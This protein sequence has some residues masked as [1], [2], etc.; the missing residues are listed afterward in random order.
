MNRRSFLATLVIPL[1]AQL[2]RKLQTGFVFTEGPVFNQH[3]DLYFSD[4]GEERIYCL[5]NG[6]RRVVRNSSKRC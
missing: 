6:H 1:Q 5:A 3:G 2:I 4:V